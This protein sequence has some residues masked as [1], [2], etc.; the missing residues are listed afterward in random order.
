MEPG[1]GN[2]A[3]NKL[4]EGID[5]EA[6]ATAIQLSGYP[7]QTQLAAMLR[8]R[9][10]Y[11]QEE[12]SYDD[13]DTLR[14]IDVVAELLL[15]EEVAD[16]V[17]FPGVTLVIECK[18]SQMPYV[19]FSS[20]IEDV[21]ISFPPVVG[22]H[23]DSIEITQDGELPGNYDYNV[24]EVLGLGEGAFVTTP[25]R[26]A[27]FSKC[28][29]KGKRLELS[30]TE[31][32]QGLVL[33][34]LKAAAHFGRYQTP[35]DSFVY[36]HPRLALPIAVL[37]AP[38]I[39]V[40]MSPAGPSLT[41]TPWVRVYRHEAEADPETAEVNSRE[42]LRALDVVHVDFFT[43][44]LEEF[45]LPFAQSFGERAVRHGQV[46]AEGIGY[47]PDIDDI[48]TTALVDNLI[49]VPRAEDPNEDTPS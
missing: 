44:Y 34:L 2:P 19:F 3:S 41:L 18:P 27:T 33:P 24:I 36:F 38:M 30:G 6:V 9:D 39:S 42:R 15:Y 47:A 29:R 21:R 45:V 4:P 28:V 32:Y 31:P 22:L 25:R 49:R 35:P 12:W 16:Q 26:C 7:V 14:A 1:S 8:E 10:W 23:Q 37:A 48:P 5:E 11:V 43:E 46:L 20:S 17:V 13:L 40:E